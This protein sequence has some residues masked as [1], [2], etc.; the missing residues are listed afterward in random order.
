MD[1]MNWG[2]TAQERAAA[3][4]C[5]KLVEAR[6]RADRAITIA[7]PPWLAYA[8]LCQLRVAPY[9][10]DLLDNFGRRSPT[11]RSP[12]LTDLRV[13]QSFMSMFTLVSFEPDRH[14]T[15]RSGDNVAV[16]YALRPDGDGTRLTVGVVFR[17][18]RL[19]ARALALGDVVMMRKQLLNLKAHAERAADA[20]TQL[21]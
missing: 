14:I 1:G 8:W 3:L 5:D 11:T 19:L 16:T 6:E 21:T 7:A 18:P 20:A 9:S 15:L 17:G 4:P 10:Y 2:A 12:E 13:G